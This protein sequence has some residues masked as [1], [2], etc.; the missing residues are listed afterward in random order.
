MSVPAPQINSAGAWLRGADA[1]HPGREGKLMPMVTV[2]REN[3]GK[4]EIYYEDHGVG[5]AA[6]ADTPAWMKGSCQATPATC[7]RSARP[8]GGCPAWST[9][10]GSW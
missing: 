4:I 10:R 1:G 6:T 2:G 7:C 5:Q 3:S 9:T 8:V